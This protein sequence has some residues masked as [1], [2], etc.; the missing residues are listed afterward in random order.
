MGVFEFTE[1]LRRQ[2]KIL[3]IGAILIV[4]FVVFLGFDFDDGFGFKAKPRY[5]STIQIAVVPSD[6]ESLAEPLPNPGASK[7]LGRFLQTGPL[8][9]TMPHSSP[10]YPG[11]RPNGFVW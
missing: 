11:C 4:G 7:V 10:S 3:I 2:K 6:L 9:R 8:F 1:A 5:E